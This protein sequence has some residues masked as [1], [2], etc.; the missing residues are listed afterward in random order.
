MNVVYYLE[1]V[2]H[3]IIDDF[4]Y[5]WE[6]DSIWKELV[7]LTDSRILRSPEKTGS[8]TNDRGDVIKSNKGLFLD[9]IYANSRNTSH[10][11]TYNRRLFNQDFMNEAATKNFVFKY[12][13]S[14]SKDTTLVSYYENSDYYAPHHDTSTLTACTWLYREPKQFT[15]GDFE[16]SDYNYKINI[17]NNRTVIF[18]GVVTHAVESVVMNNPDDTPFSCNGRYVISNFI[19]N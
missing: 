14:C 15:G 8:A 17:K 5:P 1:P 13:M 11:L 18:P 3:I 4:Y 6:L 7:F 10:I 12:F 9:E 2:P 16:F 19:S